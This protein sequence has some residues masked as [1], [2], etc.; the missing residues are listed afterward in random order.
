M[1]SLQASSTPNRLLSSEFD[2]IKVDSLIA[3]LKT[4]P[5]FDA[6]TENPTYYDSIEWL[7]LAPVARAVL[8]VT[9]EILAMPLNDD[10]AIEVEAI[11]GQIFTALSTPKLLQKIAGRRLVPGELRFVLVS[12]LLSTAIG[13]G[14]LQRVTYINRIMGLS[15]EMQH[16]LMTLIEAFP[17]TPRRS[18]SRSKTPT[19]SPARSRTSG[20]SPSRSSIRTP[21]STRPKQDEIET[22]RSSGSRRDLDNSFSS[23]TR[24]STPSRPRRSFTSIRSSQTEPRKAPTASNIELTALISWIRT[25]PQMS[26]LG[27]LSNLEVLDN[28]KV[29]LAILHVA[30]HLCG[31]PPSPPAFSTIEDVWGAVYN[32]VALVSPAFARRCSTPEMSL[33][34]RQTALLSALLCYAISDGCRERQAHVEKILSLSR[35]LQQC[36]MAVVEQNRSSSTMTPLT[37]RQSD[38]SEVASIGSRR[39]LEE[40]AATP[41]GF[42]PLRK[43]RSPGSQTSFHSVFS[44]P[45]MD[46]SMERKIDDLRRRNASLMI[47]LENSTNRE[48]NLAIKMQE[49]EMRVRRDMMK[50]ESE[51][52]RSMDEANEAH[53][54]ELA[55]LREE[56]Y[57]LQDIRDREQKANREV[58]KLRDEL[59]L[60]EHSKEKLAE[61]EEKLRKCRE[62]LEQLADLRD[63][64]KREEEAHSASVAQCLRLENEIKSMQPLREGISEL[65]PIVKE[66][67]LR[68]RN[69][70]EQLREFAARRSED[71]VQRLEEK[72]D[73][74]QRLSDRFKDQYLSTKKQLESTVIELEETQEREEDLKEEV[75]EWTGKWE[76]LGLQVTALKQE[77]DETKEGLT[78]N[79]A[80]LVE[81]TSREKGLRDDI[82]SLSN[83]NKENLT[84]SEERLEEWNKTKAELAETLELLIQ[85]QDREK[86]LHGELQEMEVKLQEEQQK[87]AEFENELNLTFDAFESTKSDLNA[88][89]D[90]EKDLRGELATLKEVKES[91]VHELEH[92][93]QVREGERISA[94]CMLN[95]TRDTLDEKARRELDDLQMNMNRLLE[96]ERV[97]FRKKIEK[98]HADYEELKR[99]SLADF[100]ELKLKMTHS[101]EAAE[102]DYE[103]RIA[104]L[105]RE[106]TIEI[107]SLRKQAEE[108]REKLLAKGKGMLKDSKGKANEIIRELEDEIDAMKQTLYDFRKE[109]EEFEH[110]TRAKV[111]SYKH[112]LQFSMSRI[113]ELTGETEQLEESIRTLEKE[114]NNLLDENE[115]YRRQLGGRYG[116]DGKTQNQ[117]EMLQKEFNAVLEEN[118]SL[119]KKMAAPGMIGTLGGISEEFDA[120]FSES[121]GMPYSRGGVSGSTLSALREEY[122]EQLQAMNDEK[123]ELMMKNSAAITDVQKAEQRSWELEKEVERL[124]H[125]V[126]SAH[127][128]LQR[129]ELQV[130]QSNME[131]S[132]IHEQSFHTA[133]EE[134][135]ADNLLLGPSDEVDQ[136]NGGQLLDLYDPQSSAPTTPQNV[137]SPSNRQN[138]NSTSAKKSVSFVPSKSNRG[139]NLNTSMSSEGPTLLELTRHN[140]NAPDGQP[141]CKQS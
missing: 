37:A 86:N 75:I 55:A 107:E 65:N 94:E 137:L 46:P 105:K 48:A 33:N 5:Q 12:C 28:M 120:D 110:K 136:E 98:S 87:S 112:K 25:F 54:K 83:Q 2:R 89:I 96:E 31:Q 16:A 3:W 49:L 117:L 121:V 88:T 38:G 79:I 8:R 123:R 57:A 118:R 47:D 40:T 7:S 84:I 92:E 11:W 128:A 82:E 138:W 77:L 69:E 36:L 127:L 76:E 53:E 45:T 22:P 59:D 44:P 10:A 74:I 122:E 39:S 4:F 113:N 129:A 56:L 130:D 32:V 70:N 116:A 104:H 30:E 15:K 109:K 27:S 119:K 18:P 42:S 17:K 26:G 66:E 61:T 115:R 103:T 126:T 131:S 67:L 64:L 108:D 71:N 29:S 91:L 9:E 19:K 60:L 125:E 139:E 14:C 78:K 51:S 140:A 63:C 21:Q 6:L 20:R 81:S 72:L 114:K 99:K 95:E 132:A 80:L 62:R 106:Y 23:V 35:D 111:S 24:M 73:D 41:S 90:R 102:S 124:K 52:L 100:E 141:E 43:R 34:D 133:G 93:K 68:L 101:L 50:V 13:E 134:V 58:V 85:S 135:Y 1:S 97:S